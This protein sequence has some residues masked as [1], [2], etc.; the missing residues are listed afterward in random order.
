WSG[1][2][3]WTLGQLR[4]DVSAL[5]AC[6]QKQDGDR[7]ALCFDNSYLFIVD[8]LAT[9]H[10]GKTPVQPGHSRE[11]LLDEQHAQFSGVRSDR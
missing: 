2:R 9:L 7:W 6:L 4:D 5:T 3:C 1:D 10:A 8:L 11:S